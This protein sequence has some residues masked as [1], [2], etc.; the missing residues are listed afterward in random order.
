MN[1]KRRECVIDSV[2][3]GFELYTLDSGHF[4]RSFKTREALK[5]YPKGVAFANSGDAVVGGSDHGL[6]YIFDVHTGNVLKKI[7][8]CKDGGVETI[9]VW[10]L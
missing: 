10:S 6:V 9:A 7:R 8:H 4:L 5:T 1:L 2:G 3:S